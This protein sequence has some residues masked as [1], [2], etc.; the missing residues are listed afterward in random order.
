MR[1]DLIYG[2]HAIHHLLIEKPE[3]LFEIFLSVNQ[4][5]KLETSRTAFQ[6]T[7]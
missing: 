3:A 5:C 7:T 6:K 4:T 2:I 1:E